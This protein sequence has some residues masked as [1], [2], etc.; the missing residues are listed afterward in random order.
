[1]LHVKQC[2][3]SRPSAPGRCGRRA[4]SVPWTGP[5]SVFGGHIACGYEVVVPTL[6]CADRA[7]VAA[8]LL[9]VC[10]LHARGGDRRWAGVKSKPGA[11]LYANI[12]DAQEHGAGGQTAPPD[13][14]LLSRVVVLGRNR[15]SA[16]QVAT[17]AMPSGVPHGESR[18][19]QCQGANARKAC[20]LHDNLPHEDLLFSRP[21]DEHVGGA[22]ASQ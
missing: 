18:G 2:V 20:V 7:K 8:Q 16:L 15:L 11:W 17:P 22:C 1:M 21:L 3:S 4:S 13:P 5:V 6:H 19:R 14:E 10:S 9:I 12:A